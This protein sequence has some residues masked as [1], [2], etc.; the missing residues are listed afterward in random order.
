M[1]KSNNK[2]STINLTQSWQKLT[3][4]EKESNNKISTINLTQT[5]QKLTEFE[6]LAVDGVAVEAQFHVLP[7]EVGRCVGP[8]HPQGVAVGVDVKRQARDVEDLMDGP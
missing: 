5:W 4:F 8:H 2:I 3:E 7:P 1:K 6:G